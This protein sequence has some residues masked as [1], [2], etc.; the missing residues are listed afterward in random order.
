MKP[1]NL[2][3]II[4][5]YNGEN[6]IDMCLASL[7]GVGCECNIVVIDNASQDD[8]VNI[9]RKNYPSVS[10]LCSK[11][12]LG[13][14]RANNIGI[15]Y[16]Y[17][18]GA[19][20]VFLLNQDAYVED[21]AIRRLLDV[22]R[23]NSEYSI[24]SP[25]HQDGTGS[26]LDSL[27]VTHLAKTLESGKLMSDYLLERGGDSAYPVGFV[28]A[29]AWLLSRKCIESV[30]LFNPVFEHYG[31]DMEY[32]HRTLQKGGTIGIVPKSRICHNRPQAI[33]AKDVG[34]SK[35][36]LLER[37]LVRYR[38][39]RRDPGTAVN[40]ISVCSRMLVYDCSRSLFASLVERLK[41][42]WFVCMKFFS[43]IRMRELGYEQYAFFKATEKDYERYIVQFESDV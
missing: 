16:A 18:K 19:D 5:T 21:G 3:I 20:F 9:I 11:V 27:F 26:G 4:V 7:M 14:G 29:A 31:E 15:K 35:R 8:T 30:G 37:A 6:H 43:I 38:L 41:L 23:G 34:V 12:N 24:L 42:V 17:E 2:S 13:F 25:L 36:Q 39:C 22:H 28:N 32:A 33:D 1:N 40:L 10:L